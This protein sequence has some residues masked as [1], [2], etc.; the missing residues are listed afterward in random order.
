MTGYMVALG[1]TLSMVVLVM[2][3]FTGTKYDDA[4]NGGAGADRISGDAGPGIGT[5]TG[6][7]L[8]LVYRLW[9][10]GDFRSLQH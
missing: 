10:W 1:M 5:Y 9:F 7:D 4:I 2:M 8:S 6:I 3:S